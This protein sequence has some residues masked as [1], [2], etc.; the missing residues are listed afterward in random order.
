[1][2]ITLS[3]RTIILFYI[4]LFSL[5]TF[6]YWMKGEVISPYRPL[7]EIA[8]TDSADQHRLENRKF[9]DFENMYIPEISEHL[10]GLRSGWL[11]LWGNHNELGRPVYQI[12][13]FSPAYFP[14]W[15]LSQC[16]ENPRRF[17]TFLSLFTCFFSGIFSI[18]FFREIG[19]SPL[20][21]LLAGS[22]MATSPLFMYWLTFPMFPAVWCWSV[23]A[24]WGVT[25]I[26]KKADL[27]GWSILAFS[28]YS[29]LMTAYP[30]PVIYHA[31]ILAGYSLFL[32]YKKQQS[33]WP[34]VWRFSGFSLSALVVG[35]IAALPVYIDLAN[36]AVDSARTTPDPSF[37]T[38]VLPNFSTLTEWMRFFVLGTSPEVFGNPMD[39]AYPLPYY[40]LSITPLIV[41][42][43]VIGLIT[44]FNKSWGWWLAITILCLL[45]FVHPLYVFAVKYFG[46]NLSRSSPLGSIMLPLTIITAYGADSLVKRSVSGEL[47][48]IVI[49][50]ATSVLAVV[51]IG[52]G[53]GMNQSVNIHWG[54]VL[55]MSSLVT[56]FYAQQKKTRPML[57]IAALVIVM[58]T[59]SYPLM[60][61]QDPEHLITTSPLVEKV[62][63]NIP[64]D[65]RFAVAKPGLTVLP[66]NLNTTLGLTSIHSYN[67]LSSRRYHTLIEAL[68][69]EIQTYGRWNGSIS[70]DYSSTMFWMSNI[71]LMLS[72]VKLNHENLEYLG[73]ESGVHLHKGISRMGESVQ[74]TMPINNINN[75]DLQISNPRLQEHFRPVKLIDQG[76]LLEYKVDPNKQSVLVLSQKFH[77]DWQAQVFRNS[78]WVP[79]KVTAV[80]KVFQ[81]VLLPQDT[82]KV[83]LKFKPFSRFAWIG[84]IFW[85]ILFI[86]L[87]VRALQSMR[88]SSRGGLCWQ[89]E[90]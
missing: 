64:V 67:S 26:A 65:S 86:L 52:I 78:K 35:V 18:L 44:S 85:A 17:I 46:F 56:L 28:T 21:S 27:L 60:L 82:K 87:V 14:S 66:P 61:R 41:F 51:L 42:F 5:L 80:N 12:S 71:G 36:L 83:R 70:P 53:F 38:S 63:A 31:Y 68:G 43:A 4:V 22:S 19:L 62:R 58:I 3:F 74:I 32:F 2:N 49:V 30:Q 6:Q 73:E 15:L 81:G 90:R 45:S 7:Q 76:D 88:K 9:S 47:S 40:G 77:K 50:A 59:I 48:H 37:F 54:M 10:G 1:M 79:A 8:L 39:T 84:H 24:L 23:G 20:P 13:G 69:G 34:E 16:T 55:V 57:L 33:G 29:L 11:K 25:R 89:D 75:A 72:P